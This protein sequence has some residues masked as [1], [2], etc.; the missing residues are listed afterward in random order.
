M[1]GDGTLA[2]DATGLPDGLT[3]I[4]ATRTITGTPT[5]VESPTVNY[6]VTDGDGDTISILFTITVNADNMPTAPLVTGFSA[7]VGSLFTEELPEGSGG[8]GTLTYDAT[9]LPDGLDF[10]KS[11]RTIT[12]TPTREE[13]PT[14]TYTVTDGDGDEA[15]TT[16]TI[17]VNPDN[18][19]S[20]PL[21][22]TILR[23]WGRYSRRNCPKGAAGMEHLPTMRRGCLTDWTS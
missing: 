5:R 12:G 19:P 17:A 18:Q 7:R 15:S 10:I 4:S 21:Y 3:F 9:G 13:S 6:S 8:D 1:G 23:K 16:F 2:Y 14:V 20:A 22:P 11:T